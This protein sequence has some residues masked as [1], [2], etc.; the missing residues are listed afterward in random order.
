MTDRREVTVEASRMVEEEGFREEEEVL[1]ATELR[2]LMQ[3]VIT[4]GKAVRYLLDQL[5]ASRFTA[6]IVLR[7][8]GVED[9]IRQ[10]R[11]GPILEHRVLIKVKVSLML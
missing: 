10:G 3:F 5:T 11:K 4:A 2:C 9:Q 6:A 8:W 7:R 1:V